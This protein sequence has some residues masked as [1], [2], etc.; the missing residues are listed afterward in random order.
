MRSLLPRHKNARSEGPSRLA[1]DGRRSSAADPYGVACHIDPNA[2]TG[3]GC[4]GLCPNCEGLTPH[5]CW[6]QQTYFRTNLCKKKLFRAILIACDA[7]IARVQ[8]PASCRIWPDPCLESES[9]VRCRGGRARHGRPASVTLPWC[10]HSGVNV[11]LC[12]LF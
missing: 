11:A 10:G 1:Q 6:N 9:R 3:S 8:G 7:I 4:T 5:V 12:M 2:K